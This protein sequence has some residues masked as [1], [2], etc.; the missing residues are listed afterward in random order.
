MAKVR[1]VQVSRAL[2]L[3]LGTGLAL[4]CGGDPPPVVKVPTAQDMRTFW[5]LNSGSCWVYKNLTDNSQ[6]TVSVDG[7]DTVRIAG[8]QIYVVN[9]ATASAPGQPNEILLDTDT[10]P[11]ELYLARYTS[12]IGAARMTETYLTDPRPLWG[13]LVYEGDALKFA[14]TNRLESASTPQGG[15]A[16]IA[17]QWTVASRDQAVVKDDGSAAMAHRL[18]Y[19]K[20][21]VQQAVYDL[22]PGY[23]MAHLQLNGTEYQVC[24]AHVCDGAGTCTG[25]PTCA[26]VPCP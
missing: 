20:G 13:K 4:S 15:A 8:K 7:P 17:H 6:F 12:G 19:T 14:P 1:A 25:A 21:G 24:L 23:G 5:G 3:V 11:G 9:Q 16:P 26:N 2:V 10:A 22:V 18:L